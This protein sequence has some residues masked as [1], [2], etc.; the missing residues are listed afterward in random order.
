M[1]SS[2]FHS[3]LLTDHEPF[4]IVSFI[5]N[6]L[7]VRFME[8]LH[9]A[10]TPHWD[11]EPVGTTFCCICN[12]RL[13]AQ[14]ARF[15]ESSIWRASNLPVDGAALPRQPPT[16]KFCA[17]SAGQDDGGLAGRMSALRTSAA[18]CAQFLLWIRA[19]E[20]AGKNE[21]DMA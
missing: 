7:R 3:D 21:T 19:L 12:K 15:M 11:H 6:K 17:F 16:E 4:F 18:R 20:S 14:K 13:Q 9:G 1:E 10:V 2:L 8:S 5:S